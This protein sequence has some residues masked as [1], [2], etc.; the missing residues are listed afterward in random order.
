[1]SYATWHNYGFGV[2][3]DEIPMADVDRLQNLLALAPELH[4][5]IKEWLAEREIADP[6]W[7]DY[8]EFDEDYHL[9]IATILQRV[10]EEAEGIEMT[11]CSD[12]DSTAYLI[13]SPRYPWDLSF[14]DSNLTEDRL[15]EIIS[16]Y[17]GILTDKEIAV[18]YQEVENGG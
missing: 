8:M 14:A 17:V 16:K 5:E 7:D 10:I 18:N 1:M 11:S 4:A 13:Y 2:C 9:G 3:T 6:T 15:R 12:Y